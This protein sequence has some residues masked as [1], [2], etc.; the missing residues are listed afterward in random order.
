M[1]LRS[2]ERLTLLD[3]PSGEKRDFRL[4]EDLRHRNF[5]VYSLAGRELLIE[6]TEGFWSGGP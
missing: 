2:D 3:P 4:P 1:L 5:A 6:L